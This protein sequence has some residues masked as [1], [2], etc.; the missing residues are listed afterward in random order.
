[1]R[2]IVGLGNPGRCYQDNRHNIGFICLNHFARKQ[3]I[4]FDRKQGKA[5]I[6]SGEV[7][8]EA[9]ILAKPQTYMNLS[10][11]SVRLL[12]R[13][14]D[15]TLDNLIVVHDDLDL[16]LGKI[17]IRRDGGSGGHKGVE[18]IVANLGSEDFPRLRIGI[19]R[20]TSDS[21]NQYDEDEIISYVLS[22]FAPEEKEVV[23]RTIP[24]VS[25]ALL[26][27]ISEGIDSAMNK[28]NP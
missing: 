25:D 14:F 15:V 6:G 3:A 1:M 16:P 2:L 22:G 4:R 9:V 21:F 5:R 11:E 17:R 26:S 23:A 28:Y 12:V 7:A 10:G 27:L 18:S 13:K 8:G 19:G 24:L 20:P